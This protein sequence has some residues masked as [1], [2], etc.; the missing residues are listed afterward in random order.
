MQNI[1]NSSAVEKEKEYI[2]EPLPK[3]PQVEMPKEPTP[4]LSLEDKLRQVQIQSQSLESNKFIQNHTPQ[5][6]RTRKTRNHNRVNLPKN[7]NLDL[8]SKF[9]ATTTN[10]NELTIHNNEELSLTTLDVNTLNL[11]RD[12]KLGQYTTHTPINVNTNTISKEQVTTLEHEQADISLA[13]QEIAKTQDDFFANLEEDNSFSDF[14]L[15]VDMTPQFDDPQD[16][17]FYLEP[18]KTVPEHKVAKTSVIVESQQKNKPFTDAITSEK[19]FRN[20]N[21]NSSNSSNNGGSFSQILHRLDNTTTT[22][23]LINDSG[24]NNLSSKNTKVAIDKKQFLLLNKNNNTN[25]SEISI[26]L[27]EIVENSAINHATLESNSIITMDELNAN[28]NTQ[29]V[30]ITDTSSKSNVILT[31]NNQPLEYSLQGQSVY[32]FN[33]QIEYQYPLTK[34]TPNNQ[35]YAMHKDF[36][37]EDTLDDIA[38]LA[39]NSKSDI[40]F[41]NIN[42]LIV[43]DAY[44][45]ERIWRYK[46]KLSFK[47]NPIWFITYH[48]ISP[49]SLINPILAVC[50]GTVLTLFTKSAIDW[51]LFTLCLVTATLI[52]IF[53]NLCKEYSTED[54]STKYECRLCEFEIEPKQKIL[55]RTLV[56]KLAQLVLL[57]LAACGTGL[58]YIAQL[59]LG[60][61]L[62]FIGIGL[63]TINLMMRYSVGS[64]PYNFTLLGELSYFMVYG[65][66]MVLASFYLQRHDFD[67]LLFY[68][69]M[70]FGFLCV[71]S[72]NLINMRDS[73]VARAYHKDNLA[74]FLGSK[75]SRMFQTIFYILAL[76]CFTNF[77]IS[78]QTPWFCYLFFLTVPLILFHLYIIHTD[79][80]TKVLN[81]QKYIT[82][83]INFLTTGIFIITTIAAIYAW[84]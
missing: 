38:T 62:I 73:Y 45:D 47:K 20:L 71:A 34:D 51:L 74:V 42:P 4:E 2:F 59:N 60:S 17:D 82:N 3:M 25:N 24:T 53:A 68:P 21:T 63:I 36:T 9:Q 12:S 43:Q 37:N 54:L 58:I 15:P 14:I 33:G 56:F 49:I 7:P 70:A 55:S 30:S 77:N 35:S 32:Q 76:F 78:L 27:P 57:A 61:S 26:E 6:K 84:S 18:S 23:E 52:Q 81:N 39:D 16:A 79:P 19:N 65:I 50:L 28:D 1:N 31:T 40:I 69:A 44:R 41:G 29:L 80:S 64:N 22:Q 75:A 46:Y 66:M 8:Y 11:A 48:I 13:I 10:F 72:L 5:T 83:I 67:T